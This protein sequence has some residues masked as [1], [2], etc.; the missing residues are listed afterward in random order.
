MIFMGRYGIPIGSCVLK[1]HILPYWGQ[2]T[3]LVRSFGC[4]RLM[5]GNCSG[6]STND[7]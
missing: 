3:D 2:I 7:L 4:R 5:H 1:W 6:L